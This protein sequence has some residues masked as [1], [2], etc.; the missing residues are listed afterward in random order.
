MHGKEW[1]TSRPRDSVLWCHLARKRYSGREIATT[2]F[3]AVIGDVDATTDIPTVWFAAELLKAY[4]DAKVILN[5]RSDKDPA[6]GWKRCF[7]EAILPVLQSWQ[8][9]WLSWFEKELFWN[10]T[11][12]LMC[13]RRM[14]GSMG[15][16]EQNAKEA[17]K[18]HWAKV[19]KALRL[20]ASEVDRER[21]R[22]VLEWTVEDGW[23][24]LCKFLD[25]P[26]SVNEV[27]P[28]HN[29][30]PEF[31]PELLAKDAERMKKASRNALTLGLAVGGVVAALVWRSFW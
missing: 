1:W 16:L 25:K 30:A 29:P 2:D 19:E 5:W 26:V 18:R 12:T 11:L 28:S 17:Y 3:D 20:E 31:A 9:W 22:Q 7:R 6:Q 21:K 4:P 10:H 13:Y 27:F 15:G 14:F 8:Y 24:T 23:E